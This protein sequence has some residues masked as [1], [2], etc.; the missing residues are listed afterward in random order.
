MPRLSISERERV[1]ALHS[2]GMKVPD[3][4]QRMK[5]E[6]VD[7]TMR[8]VYNLV[9]NYT[10]KGTYTYKYTCIY[11]AS[12]RDKAREHI[13]YLH[14]VSHPPLE[15]CNLTNEGIALPLGLNQLSNSH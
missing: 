7:I 3:I 12:Y 11:I 6:D 4:F 9:K 13:L 1:I 8:A 2:R 10:T 5:L 14:F 15:C